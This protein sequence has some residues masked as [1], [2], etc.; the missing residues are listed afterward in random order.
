[1]AKGRSSTRS[2]PKRPSTPKAVGKEWSRLLRLLPGYDPFARPGDSWF[3]EG[4][5]EA[6]L[7][8][9]ADCITHV[10]GDLAGQPFVLEPWQRS[11][12][13]NLFGWL[14]ID[15]KNRTVRR[16]KQALLYVPRKNGKT[17]FVAALALFVFFCE[18]E[19]GQ[20]NYVAASCR[21]QAGMLFRQMQ[22]MVDQCPGLK[23][24]CRVYGGK[25]EAGQ[26][27]SIVRESDLSFTRVISADARGKHGGNPH[28]VI[29]DELHEQPDRHLID[30]LTS[31]LASSNRKQSLLIYL[32]TADYERPSICNEKHR[33][34]QK[35]RDGVVDEPTFLP[36][37]WEA[38]EADDWT[39]PVV[40]ARVN[41]NLDVSV[42]REFLA[43]ECQ[44]AKTNPS[45]ENTFKRLYLNVKTSTDVRWIPAD[46]WA[47]GA[48][49]FD[50]DDLA[51]LSCYA[52]LDFGWRDD[53]A[54]LVL[55][56]HV[57]DEFF[58]L[59]WFWLPSE[60]R[61]DKRAMPTCDFIAEDLVSITPG[62]ST[63]VEAIYAVLESCRKKYDLKK[64]VLD[65]AN[66]RKQG[67]DLMNDGYEVIEFVQSKRNYNEPCRALEAAMKDG[68]LR[69]NGNAVLSWMA[70][71]VAVELNGAGEIMP[72]K[73][74]SA[75][76]IDGVC[77]LVM[78]LSEA[79]TREDDTPTVTML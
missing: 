16:Y 77:A 25:A 35:V 47:R 24:A 32:T 54:A 75:E 30:A 78:G 53:Y 63:D 45:L 64:V 27:R 19:A 41:P 57:G 31:S 39:D 15:Q 62:N 48:A 70:G 46:L 38:S 50:E 44:T 7:A 55:V 4:K 42:S 2:A 66:A 52:G 67:Q 23:D 59:C 1:M 61:R 26:S 79:M 34:A 72:K 74:K 10:E 11:F 29:V 33:H 56:F 28:L 12:V 69:H 6:A 9:V 68:K 71:N 13:A 18:D 40:W 60:G 65:P 49:P 51:G 36:A 5:A 37:I 73:V 14:R 43:S 20:Q 17:P 58:A 21:E 8:F 3:D 22:G 76:K